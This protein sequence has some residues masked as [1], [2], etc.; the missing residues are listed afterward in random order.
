MR[1]DGLLYFFKNRLIV[2]EWCIDEEKP[3]RVAGDFDD[4]PDFFSSSIFFVKRKAEKN[5]K[6]LPVFLFLKKKK[7]TPKSK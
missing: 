4:K 6:K 1:S 7:L 5:K 2:P 3:C